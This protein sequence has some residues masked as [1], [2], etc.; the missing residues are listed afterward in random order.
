MIKLML[1]TH[2]FNNYAFFCP[3]S[4]LHLTVSSPVGFTNEVTTAILRALKAKTIIDVDGVIDLKTGAVKAIKEQKVAEQEVQQ[5]EE[6]I[7]ETETNVD[8]VDEI[9]DN[10]ETKETVETIEEIKENEEVENK[11]TKKTT[12]RTTK[13]NK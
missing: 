12:K 3:V 8:T 5:T 4:K 2:K 1:D 10:D 13:K 9:V 7:K 11:T 6:N